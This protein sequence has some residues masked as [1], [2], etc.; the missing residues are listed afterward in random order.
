MQKCKAQSLEE[1]CNYPVF[2]KL[3]A[4]VI[5][6]KLEFVGDISCCLFCENL[7]LDQKNVHHQ[8]DLVRWGKSEIHIICDCIHTG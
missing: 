8:I 6:N 7:S 1:N 5:G 3:K 4:L 2:F